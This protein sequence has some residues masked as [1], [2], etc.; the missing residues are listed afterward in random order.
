MSV[1]DRYMMKN[2]AVASVFV[3]VTLSVVIFLTQSLRFLELVIEAGASS[4]A[5]W[6]LTLL[7]LPRFF[8]VILPLALMAAVLFIYS[9]MISDSEIVVMRSVGAS[10]MALARPAIVVAFMVSMILMVITLWAAPKS[11]SMMQEMRQEVKAQF[12][13]LLFREGVFNRVGNGLTLY[14][15]D[16]GADG[17][18]RGIMIHDARE[19]AANPSM[20]IAKRG[21]VVQSE[22]GYEVYVYDGSRQEFNTDGKTLA[23][24]NFERYV[25]DLPSSDPIDSRWVEPDERTIFELFSPNLENKRDVES[26]SEFRLEVHRRVLS[27]LMALVF[28]VIACSVLLLGPM[29]RRGQIG[30]MSV[31]VCGIVLIQGLYIVF[32]NLAKQSD[33]GLVFMY[34]LVFVPLMVGLFMLSGLSDMVRR[35][36]LYGLKGRS[37]IAAEVSS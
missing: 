10:P 34:G 33:M 24:L 13:T 28:T 37:A 15:R 6:V 1:F 20:I 5:F 9:R 2:L 30:R 21:A 36:F 27:P 32:Y 25:I 7:A 4:S 16:K 12:S 31:A 35:K 19:N 3:A 14:I 8:E 11:L 29:S 22:N 17:D 26:L 18:L 23:R